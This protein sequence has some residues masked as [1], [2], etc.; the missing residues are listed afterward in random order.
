M[1]E[2]AGDQFSWVC[3]SCGRRVPTRF[4]ECRCGFQRQDLPPVVTDEVTD[5][6]AKRGPSASIVVVL[7]AALGLGVAYYM[8]QSRQAAPS[9]PAATAAAPLPPQPIAAQEPVAEAS[10]TF[11]A[12]VTGNLAPTRVPNDVEGPAPLAGPPG[13]IEDVVSAALPAVASIDTGTGR[14][15]GFFIRPDIVVTN[16]HVIEGQSSVNL[17]AGGKKYTAHVLSA[18]P[19]VDVALLQVFNPNPLQATLRLG[20][21]ATARPGEEVIAIGYALGT[22]SN[23]VTRGIVSALRDAGGVTL[24]QTDAAINPG[25]SGGPLLDRTGTVIGI[26]SMSNTRA[27]GL[28]FAIAIDHATALMSGRTVAST[29]TPLEALRQATGGPSESE[30]ARDRGAARY[31]QM[32]Q[33]LA[34]AGDQIDANWQ[35]N[36][37][38]CVANTVSTGG[39]RPWFA[40]YVPNGVKTAVSNAYDCF[41]WIDDMKTSANQLKDRMDQAVEAARRDDVY[42]GTIRDIRRKY[43]M[44]WSGWER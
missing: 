5:A 7:V 1:T 28:S 4:E 18:S 42:P 36:A 33:A 2:P 38:L 19:S 9:P 6:P 20:T 13:S 34:R 43:K 31:E 39:D 44:E 11:V 30:S 25:N 12:P 24:I 3:P 8:F 40:L 41:S 10:N 21:A 22:L 32:V 35:R 15:S 23:T 26:N 16:N 17:Q 14:G 27:Q 37:K 29:Q